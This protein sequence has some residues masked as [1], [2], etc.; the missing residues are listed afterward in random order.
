M[1]SRPLL[2]YMAGYLMS[3]LVKILQTKGCRMKVQG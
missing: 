1:L 3:K 2:Q